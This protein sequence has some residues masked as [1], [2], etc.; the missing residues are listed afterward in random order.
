MP[1]LVSKLLPEAQAALA[2]SFPQD[3]MLAITRQQVL[4][5]VPKVLQALR[6]LAGDANQSKGQRAT[7]RKLLA[8]HD[9]DRESVLEDR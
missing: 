2:R 9:P 7:A 8:R 4:D 5:G 6:E 3:R 1:S